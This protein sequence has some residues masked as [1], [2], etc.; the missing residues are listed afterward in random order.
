MYLW[1]TWISE[2]EMPAQ[3]VKVVE[4]IERIKMS[5]APFLR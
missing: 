1:N 5:T 4:K 2:H 3:T